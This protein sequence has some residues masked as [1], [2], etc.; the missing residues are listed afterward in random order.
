MI[1]SYL[2]ILKVEKFP[3][4]PKRSEDLATTLYLFPQRKC[5]H[6]SSCRK[7][8]NDGKLNREHQPGHAAAHPVAA[9]VRGAAHRGDGGVLHHVPGARPPCRFPGLR[10]LGRV[11]APCGA[12]AQR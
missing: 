10:A 8:I 12:P 4:K 1:I 11:G 2:V 7:H 9:H 5:V 3:F 6:V